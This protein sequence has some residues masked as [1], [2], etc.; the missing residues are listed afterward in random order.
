[1]HYIFKKNYNLVIKN[2]IPMCSRKEQHY[3]SH[4][5][6][7]YCLR[8]IR[9]KLC[10]TEKQPAQNSVV[11][12]RLKVDTGMAGDITSSSLHGIINNKGSAS[13]FRRKLI[14]WR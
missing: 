3:P 9:V 2:F 5:A 10:R 12:K 4:I 1:M 11:P 14:C 7:L 13:T 8:V 6:V